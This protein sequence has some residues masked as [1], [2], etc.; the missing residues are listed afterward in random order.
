MQ[1]L[2][3]NWFGSLQALEGNTV[4]VIFWLA[5]GLAIL[6][7][8]LLLGTLTA[9]MTYAQRYVGLGGAVNSYVAIHGIL[10]NFDRL[11]E[12]AVQG[13]EIIGQPEWRPALQHP[14]RLV[15]RE[16]GS[17]Q[18]VALTPGTVVRL[19]GPVQRLADIR[20]A[21]LALRR[22]DTVE[23]GDGFQPE[24]TIPVDGWRRAVF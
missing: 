16:N 12:Y 23:L 20:D 3:G 7:G 6:H 1:M 18:E 14:L 24:D 22:L 13:T 9:M 17:Q 5:G 15:A 19:V 11:E 2:R 8:Q 4:T 21:A 10:A